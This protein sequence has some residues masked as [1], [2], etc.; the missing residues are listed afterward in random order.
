MC[1][2]QWY[3]VSFRT[4]E[5]ELQ[6]HLKSGALST[7]HVAFSREAGA[8]FRGRASRATIMAFFEFFSTQKWTCQES[9]QIDPSWQCAGSQRSR[10][11]HFIYFYCLALVTNGFEEWSAWGQKVYVQDKIWEQ[12]ALAICVWSSI[13]MI[14]WRFIYLIY[15]YSLHP[16]PKWVPLVQPHLWR[17]SR[18]DLPMLS[19]AIDIE[20]IWAR[21]CSCYVGISQHLSLWGADVWRVLS[22]PKSVVF[23]CG[24]A[25]AMAPDVKRSFQRVIE[26]C[27]G[28]S[29]SMAANLLASMVEADQTGNIQEW[30]NH[31]QSPES[32]VWRLLRSPIA[33]FGCERRATLPSSLQHLDGPNLHTVGVQGLSKAVRSIDELMIIW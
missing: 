14:L 23:I 18:L 5:N 20:L 29:N 2:T 26:N 31:S 1:A 27:G 15:L 9:S 19:I 22:D 33:C 4:K 11:Q 3:G 7:L 8:L 13:V 21:L 24:D 30:Q 25:R 16:E 17:S 12:S 6:A 32:G 28:R 10:L